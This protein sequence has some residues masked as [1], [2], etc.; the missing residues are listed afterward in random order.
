M[1]YSDTVKS[2]IDSIYPDIAEGAKP[3]DYFKNCTLLSCKNDDVDDLNAD[4][5]A[6]FPGEEK[7][8]LSA[9]SIMTE[10]NEVVDY[11]AYSIEYLNSL[12]VSGLPLAR[13]ALKPGCP[14][15]LL[16]NLDPSNRLCIMLPRFSSVFFSS[17][18]CQLFHCIK[19]SNR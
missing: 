12:N 9:D 11:Q 6:K 4:I 19:C 2:L 5:L 1:C 16:Q 15:M 7:V 18:F 14:L 10:R 13:L 3:D 8:L 17:V